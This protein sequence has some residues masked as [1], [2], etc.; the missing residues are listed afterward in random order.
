MKGTSL[1]VQ[2]LRLQI[3]NAE[4][5]GSIPGQITRHAA[6]KSLHAV[7]KTQYIQINK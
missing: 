3:P 5:Q 2:W 4:G 6:T 7:T 1:G